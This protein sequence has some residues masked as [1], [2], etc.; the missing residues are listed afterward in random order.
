MVCTI[1]DSNVKCAG[2]V[3]NMKKQKQVKLIVALPR[4]HL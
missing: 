4:M 2:F 1:E 3:V